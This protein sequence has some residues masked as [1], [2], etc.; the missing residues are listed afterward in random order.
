MTVKWTKDNEPVLCDT[1]SGGTAGAL[2][3]A[4]IVMIVLA[5]L[6]QAGLTALGILH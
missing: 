3:C 5:L 1:P 4:F 2:G 6:M